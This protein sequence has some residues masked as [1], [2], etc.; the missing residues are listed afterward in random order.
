MKLYYSQSS[1]FARKVLVVAHETGQATHLQLVNTMTTPLNASEAL[2]ARNPLGKIPAL[3]LPEGGTLY[4]SRVIIEYL[5]AR[6]GG[7]V[8]PKA[9]DPRWTAL[10]R[11]ALADGLMDAAIL[12]RYE[13][14]RS[15]EARS[16]AWTDGQ[17]LK[18]RHAL[19]ALEQEADELGPG[20]TVGEITIGCALGYLDFRF[21]AE[22]WREKRPALA[23][24]FESFAKRAS[25]KATMPPPG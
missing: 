21:A 19:D 6:A 1:P 16:K 7:I 20:I 3:E 18:I 15:E 13:L 17:M 11:Q 8:L 23:N 4:D 25:M 5:D 12:I 22:N 9:G 2:L 14:F 24:F 10:R